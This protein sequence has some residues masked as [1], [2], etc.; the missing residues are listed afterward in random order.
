MQSITVYQTGADGAYTHEAQA[1]ELAL[2]PGV[3][4]VPYGAL[5]T[6]PPPTAAGQVA[7]AIS[8]DSWMVM[9]DH[10]GD[11]LHRTDNDE[12]YALGA[13]INFDGQALRYSGL[14]DIPDWL[15]NVPPIPI[16]EGDETAD[17]DE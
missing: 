16:T 3:F 7:V 6:P 4:N 5:L 8:G 2:E 1:H 17:Y 10:R 11:T 14:G 13:V 12:A 9:A 15:S